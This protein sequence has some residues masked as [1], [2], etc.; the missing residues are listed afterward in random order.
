MGKGVKPISYK[1]SLQL[2]A[3]NLELAKDSNSIT[4]GFEISKIPEENY[5]TFIQDLSNHKISKLYIDPSYKELISSDDS[6]LYYHTQ[7]NPIVVPN[8]VEKAANLNIPIEFK[9][10]HPDNLA[11]IKNLFFTLLNFGTYS[12]I[13]IFILST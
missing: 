2:F 11:F 13:G 7:V 8:L 6:N 12:L 3:I 5:N 1:Q 9:D 10:F 4:N